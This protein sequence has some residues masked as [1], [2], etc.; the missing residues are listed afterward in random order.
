MAWLP[1]ARL[2]QSGPRDPLPCSPN[3]VSM[4]S[5]PSHKTPNPPLATMGHDTHVQDQGAPSDSVNRLVEQSCRKGREQRQDDEVDT[6]DHEDGLLPPTC[7]VPRKPSGL[8]GNSHFHFH[9]VEKPNKTNTHSSVHSGS[10]PPEPSSPH[11]VLC[12]LGS[13]S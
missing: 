9:S 1:K 8:C 6:L 4:T 7:L 2:A 10:S 11:L 12:G 13:R 3:G 5:M